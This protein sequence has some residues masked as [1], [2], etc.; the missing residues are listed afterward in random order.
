VLLFANLFRNAP[1]LVG[2]VAGTVIFE[3][4]QPG[5]VMYVVVE[6]EVDVVA[7]DRVLDTVGVGGIVG[8]MALIDKQ[9]RSA[10]AIART[11]C[12]L[13]PV[14]ERRFVFLVHQTPHFAIEVMRMMAD[15]LRRMNAKV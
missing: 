12:R 8:E 3:A 5:D 11:A 9:A 2:V 6:G 10:T 7:G 1:D 15:R 14:N 13:A 4:G